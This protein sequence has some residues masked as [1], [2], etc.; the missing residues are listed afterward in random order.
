MLPEF[1]QIALLIAFVLSLLLGV[2]P[3]WGAQRGNTA[4][5]LT[6]RP[7][8]FALLAAVT[9][10]YILLTVAFIQHDFSVA[11]VAKNSNTLL[12]CCTI[13]LMKLRNSN[14]WY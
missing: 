14:V 1:G 12:L 7:L 6:A 4:L 5:Q 13:L 8:A 10:S 3:L 2:L 9:V 11:Y